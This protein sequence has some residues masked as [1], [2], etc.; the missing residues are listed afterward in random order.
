MPLDKLAVPE[1]A[2]RSPGP[3]CWA[4]TRALPAVEALSGRKVMLPRLISTEA[5]KLPIA[6]GALALGPD[7]EVSR[8]PA[9]RDILPQP[10]APSATMAPVAQQNNL[11]HRVMISLAPLAF[12]TR[13]RLHQRRRWR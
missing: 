8:L 10:V 7:P 13:R 4:A 12:L 2:R 9:R 5:M 1:R 3:N 11:K 6:P